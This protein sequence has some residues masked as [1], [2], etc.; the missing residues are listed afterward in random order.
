MTSLSTGDP[1]SIGGYTVLGRLGTGGAGV[2]YLG[3]SASVRQVAVK[4]V[5]GSYA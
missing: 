1:E 5:H 3:L 4:L 2:V